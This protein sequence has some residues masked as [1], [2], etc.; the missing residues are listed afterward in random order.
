MPLA[1]QFFN[2][3]ALP[4][5]L[6]HPILPEVPYAQFERRT[7]RLCGMRLG[8]RNQRDVVRVS[9]RAF[10]RSRNPLANPRNSFL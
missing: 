3:A 1:P 8:N 4:F 7:N 9:P 2:A 5:P 6:L 10:R